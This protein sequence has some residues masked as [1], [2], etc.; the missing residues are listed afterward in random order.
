MVDQSG[1][2]G[3][4]ERAKQDI[5][6]EHETWDIEHLEVLREPATMNISCI[7]VPSRVFR[8]QRS[9]IGL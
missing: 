4:G 8:L 5:T 2:C 6:D 7:K 9:Q 3:C 1:T